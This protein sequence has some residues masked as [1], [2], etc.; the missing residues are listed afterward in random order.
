MS[1]EVSALLDDGLGEDAGGRLIEALARDEQLRRTWDTYCLIGDSL[2]RSYPLSTDFTH[3]VMKRLAD[4]P[5]VLA[6]RAR[7][8]IARVLIPLAASVAA[9]A[10]IGWFSLNQDA[11]QRA[12]VTVA[13]PAAQPMQVSQPAI[14]E[15]SVAESD[16]VR[17]RSAHAVTPYLIV[18]QAYSPG[19][20]QGVA[21]YV[22]AVAETR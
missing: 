1:S 10:A 6:P 15:A 8:P 14:A 9:M 11:P 3:K 18:H 16:Y 20:G 5:T 19:R 12:Q 21:Q 4:E 7:R 17:E 13:L 2:R 22:R